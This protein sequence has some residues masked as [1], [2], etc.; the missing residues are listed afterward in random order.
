MAYYSEWRHLKILM[1]TCVCWFL[2]D[3]AYVEPYSYSAPPNPAIC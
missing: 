3:I 1:G 2:L